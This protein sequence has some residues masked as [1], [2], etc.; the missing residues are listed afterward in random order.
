MQPTTHP[1]R[2][3]IRSMRTCATVAIV[4]GA[5]VLA[6]VAGLN[7]NAVPSLPAKLVLGIS[8]AVFYGA[9]V[10]AIRPASRPAPAVRH[11]GRRPDERMDAAQDHRAHPV[12]AEQVRA[13]RRARLASLGVSEAAALVLAEDPSFS[14]HE[15][16]RLLAKGCPVDTAL[17]ILWP[18]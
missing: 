1:V 6:A 15:L 9:M 11:S 2:P 13:W 10:G 4:A 17:R 3:A 16:Q 12:E 7:L 5:L 18:A 14:V 8:L